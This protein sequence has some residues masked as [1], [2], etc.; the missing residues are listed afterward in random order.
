MQKT[1][2]SIK[3]LKFK[4]IMLIIRLEYINTV[5]IGM[6]GNNQHVFDNIWHIWVTTFLIHNI[7][8]I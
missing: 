8:I 5:E 1:C 3:N 7:N 4:S 2:F 6:H